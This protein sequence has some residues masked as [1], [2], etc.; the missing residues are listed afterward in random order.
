MGSTEA[1]NICLD[2]RGVEAFTVLNSTGGCI[3]Y[4]ALPLL[5]DSLVCVDT[6]RQWAEDGEM[7]ADMAVA[8]SQGEA[9]YHLTILLWMT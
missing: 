8:E 3:K 9:H 5:D 6:W 2:K 1:S 7:A 4:G